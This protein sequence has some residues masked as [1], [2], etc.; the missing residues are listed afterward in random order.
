MGFLIFCQANSLAP[1]Y[2]RYVNTLFLFWALTRP[3]VF[4]AI[5]HQR[6]FNIIF[7]ISPRNI[8]YHYILSSSFCYF[9]VRF[10]TPAKCRIRSFFPVLSK[11]CSR[12]MGDA[13]TSAEQPTWVRLG[14]PRAGWGISTELFT[15]SP[16][17]RHEVT[18]AN[19][20]MACCLA[21]LCSRLLLITLRNFKRRADV[22]PRD[23][24][25]G[26]GGEGLM[27]GLYLRGLFQA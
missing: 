11:L 6:F 10:M 8:L 2:L 5:K 16:R 23:M 4:S 15:W 18:G 1:V 22:A 20:S 25:S 21:Y 12:C 24:V 7:F 27:V 13:L 9:S 26:L 14:L 3:I 19:M 17:A